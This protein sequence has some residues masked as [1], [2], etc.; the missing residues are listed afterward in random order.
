MAKVNT[1]ELEEKRN[2]ATVLV[3]EAGF[4]QRV[5]YPENPLV[6]IFERLIAKI[7]FNLIVAGKYDDHKILSLLKDPEYI[8]KKLLDEVSFEIDVFLN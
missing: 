7:T 5:N 2:K 8:K 1:N 4:L 3:R 6:F